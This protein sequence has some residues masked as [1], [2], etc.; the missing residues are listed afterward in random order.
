MTPSLNTP[1]TLALG[2]DEYR[3]RHSAVREE[4]GRRG[5]DVLMVTK[6]ANIHYLTGYEACWYPW[7]LPL[8]VA[9]VRDTEDLVVFDWTRH[10][11]YATDATLHTDTILFE[12][13]DAIE[14]ASSALS[15]LGP[16]SGRIG[17]E[18]SSPTPAAPIVSSLAE[19]LRDHG[20]EIVSGDWTV[21]SIALYKSDPEIE[22]IRR[23]ASIADD[24]LIDL[25]SRLRPGMTQIDVSVLLTQLLIERG[26]EYAATNP[27]VS[28]GSDAWRDIHG[29]PTARKLADDDVVSVRLLCRRASIP[30]EP[31]S[32]IRARPP[33]R[34]SPRDARSGRG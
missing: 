32:Y 31:R 1:H 23:A 5:I 25:G 34:A 19:S 21:D 29:F 24:A 20:S 13:S 33:L 17:L 27:L 30:R 11:A 9:V 7:R 12:Y 15:R 6:P 28:S 4:M 3:R 14:V 8:G 2:I 18:W 16:A 26:S 10:A 22:I